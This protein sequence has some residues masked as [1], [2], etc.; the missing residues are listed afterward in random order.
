MVITFDAKGNPTKL[1]PERTKRSIAALDFVRNCEVITV[2]DDKVE[3][4]AI[5]YV[6]VK[7]D[8]VADD[9][10]KRQIIDNCMISIPEYMVPSDVVFLNEMPLNASKKPDLIELERMYNTNTIN[11]VKKK[12]RLFQK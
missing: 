6:V 10:L 2:H 8:V 9:D 12:K 11:D 4:T 3:N 5:A 1:I 7:D